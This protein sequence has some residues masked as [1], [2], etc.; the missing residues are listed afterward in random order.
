L[1]VQKKKSPK[2]PGGT[3]SEKGTAKALQKGKTI[4]ER[5]S[6]IT[7]GTREFQDAAVV[8]T[9]ARGRYNYEE[10]GMQGGKKQGRTERSVSI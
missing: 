4:K 3:S 5:Q 1:G 7:T 9:F 2:V 10:G 8:N 6:K